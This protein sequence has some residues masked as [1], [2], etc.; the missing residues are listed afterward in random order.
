M[1]TLKATR[2]TRGLF[3]VA[4]LQLVVTPFATVLFSYRWG[5]NG[6][7]W[8][9]VLN[10]VVYTSAVW[11]AGHRVAREYHATAHPL[12]PMPEDHASAP[13]VADHMERHSGA[14]AIKL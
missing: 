3:H 5:V 2:Q 13:G 11:L 6:T 10:A 14:E 8:A 1:L 9:M 12:D 7:A 4:I